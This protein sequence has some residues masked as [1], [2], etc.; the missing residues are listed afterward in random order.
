MFLDLQVQHKGIIVSA[1]SFVG[2]KYLLAFPGDAPCVPSVIMPRAKHARGKAF[3]FSHLHYHAR[4]YQVR[5]FSPSSL[6]PKS[7]NVLEDYI[8]VEETSSHDFPKWK[9]VTSSRCVKAN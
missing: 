8:S 2:S 4:K 7:I 5:L 9:S 1:T 3:K 6:V